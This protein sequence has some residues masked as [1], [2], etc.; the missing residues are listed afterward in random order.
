MSLFSDSIAL[1]S[2]ILRT[3][4]SQQKGLKLKGSKQYDKAYQ[5][6]SCPGGDCEGF[7]YKKQYS[8]LIFDKAE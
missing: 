3:D 4:E 5:K 1:S 7:A 2:I 6:M 8:F